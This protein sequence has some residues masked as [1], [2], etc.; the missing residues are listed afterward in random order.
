[1][2]Q[3]L[4]AELD[5]ATRALLAHFGF[6]RETFARLRARL[7]AGQAE[8]RDNRLVGP[9]A[10]PEAGDVFRLPP[11][12]S[13]E[14]LRLHERGLAELRAGHVAVAI[15]AGGMA[16]RFGGLVKAAVP[17]LGSDSFLTLKLRDIGQVAALVQRRL[18]VCL[19]TSFATDPLIGALAREACSDQIQVE[20]FP[21]FI[22]LRLLA[23]GDLLRD[24]AGM[25]SPYATGHGDFSFALRRAGLLQSLREDGVRYLFLSNVDNLAATL[26]PATIALHVER[27]LALSFEVVRAEPEDKGGLPAR[28]DGT[29]QIIEALRYPEGFDARSIPL[30]SINNFV[31][32]VAALDRDFD[33]TGFRVTKQVDGQPAVQFERL[34]N[35]LTAHLP[36]GALWVERE[37]PDTRFLPVKDPP[38]L[39]LRLPAIAQVLRTRGASGAAAD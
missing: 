1:M 24:R 38:E 32:N 20:T 23:S 21:Q 4:D 35:Q 9:L 2:F 11:L 36:S 7:A 8:D 12:G 13:S 28:L 37:G 5:P 6:E 14:R 25:P 10:A 16:T 29:L 15:L 17:V 34:V 39:A 26:D 22:S 33:L 19:M 31:M 30:F 18:R 3:P 27:T